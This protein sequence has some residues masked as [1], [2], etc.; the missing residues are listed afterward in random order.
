MKREQSVHQPM[1]DVE[2]QVQLLNKEEAKEYLKNNN[3]KNI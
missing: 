1:L 3:Y 2:G